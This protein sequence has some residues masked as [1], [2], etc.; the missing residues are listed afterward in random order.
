MDYRTELLNMVNKFSIE[1]VE[2]F[3]EAEMRIVR[4]SGFRSIRKKKDY[5][6]HIAMLRKVKSK[7]LRLDPKSVQIPED[8]IDAT[9]MSKSFEKCLLAFSAVCDGYVQMQIA[10]KES[11]ETDY[12]IE[13]LHRSG[14][15]DES[16]YHELNSLCSSIRIMLIRSLQTAKK[17]E[18]EAK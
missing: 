4:D 16:Q 18:G 11:N 12:W 9:Y 10:L 2:E 6:G 5:G 8:D 14:Y 7:A 3:K 1:S 13:L 17:N 15:L